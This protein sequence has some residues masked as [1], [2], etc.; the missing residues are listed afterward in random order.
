M[1]SVVVPVYNEEENIKALKKRL[2]EFGDSAGFD[3]VE[4]VLVDDG[5]SDSTAEKLA[6]LPGKDARFRV[7]T[8][9]RNFGHQPAVSAGLSIARGSVICVIDGDLQDPPEAIATLVDAM[10]AQDADVA[11]GVRRARKEN[12]FKRTAYFTFYRL[13]ERSSDFPIPLD[14]GDF[15]CMT[16]RVVDKMLEL[17]ERR[18]FVRGIRAWVGYKQIPVEYERHARHAGE[19]KYSFTKLLG[20]AYDGLFSNSSLPIRAFQMI[21]TTLA[22]GAFLVAMLYVVL[23]LT[24]EDKTN[25]TPGFATLIVSIWFLAGVQMLSL[26]L[27]GEY[28]FRAFDESRRRPVSLIR[29]VREAGTDG[30]KPA[31][32]EVKHGAM[33]HERVHA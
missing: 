15:A 19:P 25:W 3:R 26:G 31:V 29:D 8:L 14:T 23:F 27:I 11:Y 30:E 17:P 16:R 20:L 24:A 13:L 1:L 21:G 32:I 28:V 9:T 5:S 2:M 6:K 33:T 12:V 10:E 22:I 4:F 7:A 18:R